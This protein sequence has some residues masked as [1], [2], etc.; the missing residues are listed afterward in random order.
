MTGNGS[1]PIGDMQFYDNY[2]PPL[3]AG[4]SYT[5][6]VTQS[7]TS[8]ETPTPPPPPPTLPQTFTASAGFQVQ[9]PRFALP[10]ADVHAMFPPS[11]A[12]GF[13]GQNLPHIVLNQ[14]VLP[15][16]RTLA[17]S[18]PASS[19]WMAVL[20]L[21][22]DEIIPPAGSPPAGSISN[23]TL[24]GTYA[25]TD[26]INPPSGTLGPAITPD[27][28]D[29]T[30]CRAID[31]STATFQAVVPLATELSYLAHVRQVSVAAKTTALAGDGG[32]FSVVIGNRFPAESTA[33]GTQYVAHLVS[34]EGFEAYLVASP[35]WPS[36]ITAVRL[37]SL[38]SWAFTSM[39]AAGDFAQLMLNVAAPAAPPS[40]ASALLLRLPVT[41]APQP[42]GSPAAWAQQALQQGY[43]ALEYDTRVGD[44][45]FAWYHGPFV[46]APIAPLTTAQ[47]FVSSAAATVYDATSGTFDLSYAAAFELGRLLAL[48]GHTFAT[49]HRRALASLRR[50]TDV[51]R[52]RMRVASGADAAINGTLL[53]PKAVSRAFVRWIGDELAECLPAPG[54][55]SVRP[56]SPALT[57][58]S[59]AQPA[60]SQLRALS[61]RADVQTLMRERA[62]TL[63]EDGPLTYVVDW[64]ATLRLLDGVPFVQLVPDARAL[65][66]ESIRFFYVDPNYLDALCDGAQSVGIHSTRDAQTQ[67]L[68]RDVVRDAAVQRAQLRRTQR[69]GGGGITAATPASATTDAVAGFL[70]RSAVIS[71]WPGLEVHAYAVS[72]G[73]SPSSPIPLL[74]MDRL[75]PDVLLC[76]F[77]EVPAWIEIDEPKE[78]L[79]F[80]VEDAQ[81][82]T[83]DPV[84]NLRYLDDASNDM[85]ATSGTLVPLTSSF[86]RDATTNV[87]DVGAW[88]AQ[89]LSAYGGLNRQ[90]PA[91]GSA[92]FAIQMVRAPEQMVFQNQPITGAAAAE[93]SNG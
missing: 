45:T 6:A 50:A 92:A 43:A 36:G 39:P 70:L 49:S 74:R 2:L 3:Y 67:L 4:D 54:A 24:A 34:L 69:I 64:L 46:P 8:S 65:P 12:S 27:P 84:I 17:S 33:I 58:S 87:L 59:D 9:A 61:Q 5:I 18:V 90:A 82:G 21:T 91:W 19:P 60:A 1:L 26:V 62:S 11:N 78:G 10:P 7:V 57:S 31:L 28:W 13:F 86:L 72:N 71:G 56:S 38:A 52:E 85:G 23:P 89:L 48:S 80:G 75:A 68:V 47:P 81:G 73:S 25:V 93:V 22:A 83:G 53:E 42:A 66:P 41:N 79:A 51:T 44:Q 55:P 15:W 76:L 35:S 16:E 63:I 32:W 29:E 88:Q 37:V 40:D 30:T 77:G 14:R 20:L